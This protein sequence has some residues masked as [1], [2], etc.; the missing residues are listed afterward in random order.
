M[1]IIDQTEHLFRAEHHQG[2]ASNTGHGLSSSNRADFI[3]LPAKITAETAHM[4]V[5]RAIAAP[6]D[7]LYI[8]LPTK[9]ITE[10]LTKPPLEWLRVLQ[11]PPPTY[12][13]PS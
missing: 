13:A 3:T 2:T 1:N 10:L 5:T 8:T 11:P 9:N 12:N 4:T 6:D 7:K